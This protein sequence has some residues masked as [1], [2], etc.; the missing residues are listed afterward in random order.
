[1]ALIL[2]RKPG[3]RIFVTLPTGEVVEITVLRSSRGTARIGVT[4]PDHLKI[5][6]IPDNRPAR[7]KP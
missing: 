4:A 2:S 1:M 6:R 5:R 3:Q 7:Q